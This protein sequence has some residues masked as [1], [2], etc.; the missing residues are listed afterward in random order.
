M[1]IKQN[2]FSFYDFLGYFTPGALFLY[3]L[4]AV[5]GHADSGVSATASI[6]QRL[7]FEAPELYVPFVLAAYTC[8]HLLSFISSITIEQY[9]LWS[10]GYPSKYLMGVPVKGYFSVSEAKAL[11]WTLRSIVALML[12]P[13]STL[14]FL[15][16]KLLGMRRLYAKP[17]DGLLIGLLRTKIA[18][19]VRDKCGIEFPAV[20]AKPSESDYFRFVYH[21][22]VENCPYH[23][24]KM[25]NYV[26][27]YG[28]LRTIA[29]LA[30]A[31]F[32]I[33]MWHLR[34]HPMRASIAALAIAG[35]VALCFI[36]YLGFVKFYRRFSL[37]ALMATSVR[38]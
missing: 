26:A 23:L 36:L 32:W 24:P 37:E 4:I 2:P 29:L 20:T 5:A 11:R 16:G 10:L 17:L 7:S 28:Y 33:L 21:F 22:A 18:A 9:A 31:F 38:T 35:A 19:L 13:I 15:L 8:G 12:L 34:S 6:A 1:E 3:G 25:Q 30:V 14:D 27:L